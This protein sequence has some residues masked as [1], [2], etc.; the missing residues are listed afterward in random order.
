MSDSDANERTW[1][2]PLEGKLNHQREFDCDSCLHFNGLTCT[3]IPKLYR[4]PCSGWMRAADAGDPPSGA[5]P[6]A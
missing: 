6:R 1:K 4:H 3:H 5:E 2:T